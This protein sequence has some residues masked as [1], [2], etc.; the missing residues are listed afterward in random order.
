LFGIVPG[1]LLLVIAPR[2]KRLMGE[3]N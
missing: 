1:L 3:V 2:I